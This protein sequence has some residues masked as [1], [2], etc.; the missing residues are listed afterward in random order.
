MHIFTDPNTRP[1]IEVYDA[2]SYPAQE[3]AA[4][5]GGD[6]MAFPEYTFTDTHTHPYLPEFDAD[7]DAVMERAFA[8][9]VRIMILPNVSIETIRPMRELY[10][11]YPDRTV[12]AMGL[13]PSEVNENWQRD[14]D[15]VLDELNRHREDYIA[16]GEVGIDL[17][18]DR[19][20]EQEQ[21]KS[22]DRQFDAADL[23]GL[24]VIIHCRE[25]L[26]RTLEVLDSHPSLRCVFHCF[27]GDARDV[28]KSD[29]M[30]II[31]SASEEWSPSATLVCVK[32]CLK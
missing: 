17:Y 22:L 25:G 1:G 14:T 3:R 28:E 15:I 31:I 13:H 30:V 2:D 16:L 11:R 19:T 5:A 6:L 20:Y 10:G 27:G 18:W 24:P 8:S 4:R 12:M 29:V 7:R 32:F 21:M 23:L 9:G 26:D